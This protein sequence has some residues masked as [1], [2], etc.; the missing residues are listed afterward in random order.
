MSQLSSQVQDPNWVSVHITKFSHNTSPYGTRSFVWVHVNNRND[1]DL[2]VRNSR[3]VD[4]YGNY[5]DRILMKVTGGAEVLVQKLTDCVT[6][7]LL[8]YDQET[9]DLSQLIRFCQEYDPATRAE[10]PVDIV[11][12]SPFMAM[13]YPKTINTVCNPFCV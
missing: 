13:R 4:D 9:Q 8:T 3:V 2:V 1:L 6:G 12:K 7:V 5:Q 10:Y 11:V